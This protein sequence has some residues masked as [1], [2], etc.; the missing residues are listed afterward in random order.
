MSYPSAVTRIVIGIAAIAIGFV[1]AV[2]LALPA[3]TFGQTTNPT[4]SVK[5]GDGGQ[6]PGDGGAKP[7]DSGVKPPS[8][9]LSNLYLWFLGFIGIAALLA[10][11]IGGVMYMF[12]GANESLVG[13]AKKWIWNAIWGI[14]IAA[15]SFLLLNTIN[16]DLV[17]GFNIQTVIENALKGLPPAPSA[18][19]P[20]TPIQGIEG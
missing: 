4:G 10:L 16:P 6:E 7:G 2:E 15:F 1:I 3:E 19:P 14:V 17:Q 20:P 13:E 18:P 9:Y 5:P 12:A 11:V 8:T